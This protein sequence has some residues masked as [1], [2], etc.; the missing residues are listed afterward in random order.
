MTNRIKPDEVFKA[1][2]RDRE[3]GFLREKVTTATPYYE[4]S[5]THKDLIDEVWRDDRRRTGHYRVRSHP[6]LRFF[7]C[8]PKLIPSY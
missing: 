4:A 3:S 8:H 2:E 6:I 5:K 7:Y 1:V